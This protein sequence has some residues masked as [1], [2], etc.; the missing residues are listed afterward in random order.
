MA[1][2]FFDTAP[3]EQFVL[4]ID[5]ATLREAER[6]IRSCESC[7]PEAAQIAFVV[8]LDGLTDSDPTITD[9]L[10]ESPAKCPNC[11][12]DVVEKTLVE[13]V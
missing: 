13:A 12:R 4:R 8:V 11:Q 3:Q 5:A 6:L 7:N 10:L 2:G 1:A 9:Y